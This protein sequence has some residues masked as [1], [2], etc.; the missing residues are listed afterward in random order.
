MFVSMPSFAE[1]FMGLHPFSIEIFDFCHRV[2]LNAGSNP[3]S[4]DGYVTGR[5]LDAHWTF[6]KNGS[7]LGVSEQMQQRSRSRSKCQEID[8]LQ[9]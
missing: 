6:S 1:D 8:A 4:V 7:Y 9:Q 5:F 2:I 3:A